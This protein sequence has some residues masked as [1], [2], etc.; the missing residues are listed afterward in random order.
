MSPE[1]RFWAKVDRTG[2]CWVW[3]GARNQNGYGTFRFARSMRLA[4]RVAFLLTRGVIPDGLWVLHHCDNPP[5]VNPAH[6]YLGTVQDNVRD[7]VARGRQATGLRNANARLTPDLVLEAR[8]RHAGGETLRAIAAAVGVEHTTVGRAIRGDQWREV[9]GGVVESIPWA[10]GRAYH[11]ARLTPEQV[12]EIRAL[13]ERRVPQRA[14]GRMFG[15]AQGT[16]SDI[17]TGRQ[18]SHVA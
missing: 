9:L 13:A 1:E 8:R 4:H 12:V 10:P 14:I 2:E 5:C 18:W 7:M 11:T 6:L 3:T 17:I 16:V 15:V